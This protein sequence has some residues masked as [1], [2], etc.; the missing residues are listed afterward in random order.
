MQKRPTLL[1]NHNTA[2]PSFTHSGENNITKKKK[3]VKLE[4][5]ALVAKDIEELN[6]KRAV[7]QEPVEDSLSGYGGVLVSSSLSCGEDSIDTS[8]VPLVDIRSSGIETM[9]A[10][11]GTNVG[12]SSVMEIATEH[13][14]NPLLEAGY[15]GISISDV[16]FLWI[17][18]N[19]T[20][21][22]TFF[23]IRLDIANIVPRKCL[24]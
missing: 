4:L 10:T 11:G 17:S 15:S 24:I 3:K 8:P 22:L 12:S 16:R 9:N 1:H 5:A 6:R 7:K 20:P 18:L 21:F 19:G 2:S 23:G 14:D 13:A